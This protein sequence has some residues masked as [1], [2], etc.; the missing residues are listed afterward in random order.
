MDSDISLSYAA[1]IVLSSSYSCSS[2]ERG[3]LKGFP[4]APCLGARPGH[5]F[6]RWQHV[7]GG[8]VTVSWVTQGITEQD[9][10]VAPK[11]LPPWSSVQVPP[12]APRCWSSRGGV[13]GT[14]TGKRTCGRSSRWCQGMS[15]Q[16]PPPWPNCEQ[17]SAGTSI[18]CFT[19]RI[20]HSKWQILDSE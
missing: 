12:H 3:G 13:G 4:V 18:R 14:Q 19:T 1:F 16:H 7:C 20:Y 2:Q 8:G 6:Y 11:A 15:C 10:G 17:L 9:T 5:R